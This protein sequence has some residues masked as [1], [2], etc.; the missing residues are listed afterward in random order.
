MSNI[1]VKE[2]QDKCKFKA[3]VDEIGILHVL[4]LYAMKGEETD[5]VTVT[6]YIDHLVDE[7]MQELQPSQKEPII[8]YGTDAVVSKYYV[9]DNKF[10]I[11]DIKRANSDRELVDKGYYVEML[12]LYK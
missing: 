2:L 4:D 11:I 9:E 10:E 12:A 7:L 1:E 6:N 8:L 3:K 5:T